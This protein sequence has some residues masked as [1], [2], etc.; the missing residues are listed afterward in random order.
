MTGSYA[1]SMA[2]YEP[3]FRKYAVNCLLFKSKFV[4]S[5][6]LS[7]PRYIGVDED[8]DYV[9]AMHAREHHPS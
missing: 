2:Y 4:R 3:L 7:C 9:G 6:P 1:Q 8:D 5:L